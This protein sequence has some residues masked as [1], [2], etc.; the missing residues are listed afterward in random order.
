MRL[1]EV[2][3]SR[4]GIAFDPPEGPSGT[5]TGQTPLGECVI[6]FVHDGA[7]GELTLTLVRKPWLLPES[8]LWMGFQRT[9][10]AAASGSSGTSPTDGVHPLFRRLRESGDPEPQTQC[11]AAPGCPLSRA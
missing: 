11:L 7:R 3:R 8:L 1:K 4:Y 6:E 2:G 9:S 10:S 5:A